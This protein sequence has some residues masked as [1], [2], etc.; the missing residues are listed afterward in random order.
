MSQALKQRETT[1]TDSS[2]FNSYVTNNS[3]S[4]TLTILFTEP[5]AFLSNVTIF[6]NKFE[7]VVTPVNNEDSFYRIYRLAA[8]NYT[9]R[10]EISGQIADSEVVITSDKICTAGFRDQN[11]AQVLKLPPL[12]SSALLKDVTHYES[13]HE[14][15]L[16]PA[17]RISEI[18][19]YGNQITANINSG[20]FIFLRYPT[21]EIYQKSG[22]SR[23]FWERF[24]L[25]AQSGKE[26]ARFPR[27]CNTDETNGSLGFSAN[28][29]P[30]LYFFVYSDDR[31]NT[32]TIP[33]YIYEGWYTQF[34]MTVL[35]QPLFGS[36]RIFLS[37]QK[38]FNPLAEYNV[39]TD[40]CL[41]KLQNNDYS[42]DENLIRHI[43]SGKFEF[44]MLGLLGAYMYLKSKETGNDNL[45][46]TIVQNLQLKILRNSD[47][48]DILALN[49]LSYKH[50][51]QTT[52]GNTRISLMQIAGTPM[53]RIAYNIICESAA[54][55]PWLINENNLNDYI[56]EHQALDSPFNTITGPFENVISRYLLSLDEINSGYLPKDPYYFNL[57]KIPFFNL[58]NFLTTHDARSPLYYEKDNNLYFSIALQ[59][60]E[61]ANHVER[62]II[63]KLKE[64]P[65]GLT[66][67]AIAR[68]LKIPYTTVDRVLKN[69]HIK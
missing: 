17:V 53:L 63:N 37:E 10:I 59:N 25:Y 62:A 60:N 34:F 68:M 19:T 35:N 43:A 69:L 30:G 15:Y 50:F 40:V 5:H 12:Y 7:R 38:R 44:P 66:I 4:F 57:I 58:E 39:Y 14:Y 28:L 16:L 11:D 3:V 31:E 46:R 24:R 1:Q 32:R 22:N 26:V 64:S 8:G 27:N 18:N 52:T 9:V 23:T 49:L 20:L 47:S 67:E 48:P 13:S 36:I 41:C 54:E 51:E 65:A 33:L 42:L 29:Y 21:K 61:T 6:N 56:A 45:F 55:H 2:S